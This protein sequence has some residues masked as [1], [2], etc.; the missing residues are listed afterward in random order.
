MVRLD[1]LVVSALNPPLPCPWSD[2]GTKISVEEEVP[3]GRFSGRAD[4]VLAPGDDSL[5]D[6]ELFLE[7]SLDFFEGVVFS[8]EGYRSNRNVLEIIR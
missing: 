8:V 1:L 2:D 4:L 7:G 3:G 5:E 6:G